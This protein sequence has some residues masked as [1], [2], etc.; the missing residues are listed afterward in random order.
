[1]GSI[2]G[3]E[4]RGTVLTPGQRGPSYIGKL[5]VDR[6]VNKDLRVRLTGSMYTSEQGDEQHALRRRPRRL[7]LLL[8]AREHRGDRDG[9]EGLRAPSTRASRTR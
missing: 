5:G 6:Q 1:M 2:T 9:A 8:R 3:G 7:A 4:I